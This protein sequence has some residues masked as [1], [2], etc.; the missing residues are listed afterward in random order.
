[1]RRR[2]VGLT[3]FLMTGALAAEPSGCQGKA[4]APSPH[5][6]SDRGI[7]RAKSPP[8]AKAAIDLYVYRIGREP[9]SLAVDPDGPTDRGGIASGGVFVRVG[10][11]QVSHAQDVRTLLTGIEP[12][13]HVPIDIVRSGRRT[14][15]HVQAAS[16]SAQRGSDGR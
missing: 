8:G 10:E 4:R 1:M 5:G 15:V 7:S 11:R 9:G 13:A 6:K 14:T 12:G 16:P 3:A 2:V